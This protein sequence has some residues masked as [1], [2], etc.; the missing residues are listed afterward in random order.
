M[1]YVK[2]EATDVGFHLDASSYLKI[3]GGLRDR[4][5]PRAWQF[6]SD[7][8][9]Y[10]FYKLRCVKDLKLQAISQR[11]DA[12]LVLRFGPNP[13]KHETGLT[14]TYHSES[15]LDFHVSGDG[16]FA[17]GIGIVM[18]DELLPSDCG[19]SHEIALTSGRLY[20]EAADMT[21]KWE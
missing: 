9:H 2:V 17:G 6:A 21:A 16:N 8:D 4:L 10:D 15:L 13:Y 20:I 7:G 19:C 3:V 14:V 11:E 18:L 12:D 1:R 5:P